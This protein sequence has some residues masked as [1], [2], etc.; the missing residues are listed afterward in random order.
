MP[1][2]TITPKRRK[3][4]ELIMSGKNPAESYCGAYK[5]DNMGPRSIAVEA[6][7]LMLN[8]NIA[9]L[10]DEMRADEAHAKRVNSVSIQV[11]VT[12]KLKELM[13]D[14]EMSGSVQLGAAI[15]LG[16][17]DGMFTDVQE[18]KDT[19]I[20]IDAIDKQIADRIKE[21]DNNKH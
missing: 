19:T 2:N 11:I 6:S 5:A 17:T 20:D 9:L 4:A 18:H 8:P 7:R 15:A 10:I 12:K 21:L 3:F 13:N 14:K 1:R 16:K